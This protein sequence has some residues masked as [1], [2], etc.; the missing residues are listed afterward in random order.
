MRKKT[1]NS[2][3]GILMIVGLVIGGVVG[4]LS[5]SYAPNE[6][7]TQA[8]ETTSSVMVEE[9]NDY[10]VF[11]PTG[12]LNTAGIIFYPG[13]KV[14]AEAYAPLMQRL[15]E[16]GVTSFLVEMPFNLAVFDK[17]A[18]AVVVENEPF[19]DEWFLAGHSLGGAMAASYVKTN[20][21]I[22]SGLILLAAYTTEDLKDT[23]L[24][25][26][27]IYGTEDEVL[28]FDKY[29]ENKNF[30][31]QME[32]VII[33]GGNHAQFGHYG[34]QAGDGTA[35]IPATEQEKQTIEAIIRFIEK[36]N[37]HKKD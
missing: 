14:E 13:G 6:V 20:A 4:Y 21:D 1:R 17:K 5:D 31:P 27:S 35:E 8:L 25:V 33:Q 18:A 16:Q 32:E 34:N 15:A 28:N 11:R 2:V 36:E 23:D 29:K 3:V 7:A 12:E 9:K 22:F 37:K 30:V 10:R 19:I 24:P 26:L